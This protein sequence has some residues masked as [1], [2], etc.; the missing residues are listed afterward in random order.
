MKPIVNTPSGPI[1]GAQ[2]PA[3]VAFRGIP[4]A[5]PPRD[6]R[7]WEAPHPIKPW[8]VTR[9]AEAYGP[10]APQSPAGQTLVRGLI[11]VALRQQS[12]DCLY[13]NIWTPATDGR[14]R[15]VLVW[16]HGGAFIMG[17]GSTR[18]YDGAPLA[19][20]G[21]VVVVTINYRLGA[22]GFLDVSGVFPESGV[23]NLGVRDQIAALAWVRDHIEAF[24]GDPENVTLF[25]ES[26]GGMSVGTLLGTPSAKG[27]FHRAV[28][29]SGA[30][31][32]VSSAEHARHVAICFLEELQAS[33]FEDLEKASVSALL[34]AQSQSLI[35]MG[36]ATGSLPWQ[37]S[38]DN[39]LIP[40]QPLTAVAAG[41]GAQVP[42]L[43][44]TTR[45][46]WK[47]FM[48]GDLEGRR[49]DEDGLHRRLVRTL[50]AG[51]DALTDRALTAYEGALAGRSHATPSDVWVALQTDRIFS[52]PAHALAGAHS[53][54]VRSTHVYRF[55]WSPPFAGG[56]VGACH[57]LDIPFVFG[58]YREPL[59]RPLV[60]FGREP[61]RLSRR[62]MRAW[63]AFARTGNPAHS[64]LSDWPEYDT[65][66][67]KTLILGTRP[68]VV[69][70]PFRGARQFWEEVDS[71]TPD[72]V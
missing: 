31:H 56:L 15:P 1:Q 43:I 10:S 26:A 32:N 70:D 11:G 44:G 18:I 28:A 34:A 41:R 46:E 47:L 72:P 25:G 16:I 62:M 7:R 23:S 40:E 6:G 17:S 66:E 35:R 3:V 33:A 37:P 49:L 60:G 39:D 71:L 61:G 24:G 4:Y 53:R 13:L 21:D 5:Q 9:P 67:R 59:L 14:R 8:R 68:R 2:E 64:E 55:D 38:V 57:G 65:K 58:T 69:S 48:L 20:I 29:Q 30:A 52:H 22:L 12:Q 42:L 63:S 36:I 19:E 50:P 54:H 27:L 45:D 51:G